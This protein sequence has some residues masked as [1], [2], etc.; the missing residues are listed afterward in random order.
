M[1]N[2]DDDSDSKRTP[3]V[4]KNDNC[5]L[6]SNTAAGHVKTISPQATKSAVTRSAPELITDA[7]KVSISMIAART[8]DIRNPVSAT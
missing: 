3:R 8:A 1:N 2:F 7:A 6:T 5:R 4:A